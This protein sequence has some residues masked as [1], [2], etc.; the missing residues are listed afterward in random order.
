MAK[1]VYI[2]PYTNIHGHDMAILGC[3]NGYI[4][5]HHAKKCSSFSKGLPMVLS[6]TQHDKIPRTRLSE[7]PLR[8]NSSM[9]CLG[10]VVEDE[11]ATSGV[12][13]DTSTAL[14]DEPLMI[15][16]PCYDFLRDVEPSETDFSKSCAL[17]R[18]SPSPTQT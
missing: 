7:E 5:A 4:R 3:I 9:F 10:K 11:Q 6:V 14:G 15:G 18:K 12:G 8:V 16:L 1:H 13:S 17:C 2:C